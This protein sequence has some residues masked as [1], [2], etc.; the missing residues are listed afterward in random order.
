MDE[1]SKKKTMKNHSATHLL[2]AALRDSLGNH[3]AQQGSYVGPDRLRFDFTHHKGLSEKELLSV[4]KFVNEEIQSNSKVETEVCE[5]DE[6]KKQGATALFGE[7]YENI[8]RVLS[9]GSKSKE[10]C[11][12]THCQ[13]TGDIGL[14]KIISETSISAGIRRIEALTGMEAFKV[15]KYAK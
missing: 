7:K 8:V 10:L 13:A 6:A 4:E 9:M 14:F 11:G 1:E 3:V 2:H 5:F 12:G 15:F